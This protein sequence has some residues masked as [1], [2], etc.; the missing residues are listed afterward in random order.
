MTAEELPAPPARDD[1][2]EKVIEN[3]RELVRRRLGGL[4]LAV[5]D[6]RL[7]GIETKALVGDPSLGSPG[8]WTI[9]KVVQ[10]V[11]RL[12]REFPVGCGPTQLLRPAGLSRFGA[13]KGPASF[14][15]GDP[16]PLCFD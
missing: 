16:G 4:G 2:H 7:D 8:R 15:E 12:A 13:V 5:L 14:V 6:A 1:D 3:F 11:K 9:K 10:D